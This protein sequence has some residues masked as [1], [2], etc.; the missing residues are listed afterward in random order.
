MSLRHPSGLLQQQASYWE[1]IQCPFFQALLVFAWDSYCIRGFPG[2]S[3]VKNPPAN[4]GDTGDWR[5]DPWVGKVPLEKEMATHSSIPPWRI[6][7]TEWCGGIQSRV[8]W[9]DTTRVVSTHT[10]TH[11]LTAWTPDFLSEVGSRCQHSLIYD[12]FFNI[13]LFVW[14]LDS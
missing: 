12:H 11:T 4:E 1:R 13:Y 9:T 14:L 2:G 7:W 3:V 8:E 10:H 6:P 5:F